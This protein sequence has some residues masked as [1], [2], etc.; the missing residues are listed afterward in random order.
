MSFTC[1]GTFTNNLMMVT[2][3][4]LP[5][6][7]SS[8]ST[9]H[10]L[11]ANIGLANLFACTVLKP[12]TSVYIG[13]G[14]AM[15]Q[16]AVDV[17]FC[18]LHTLASWMLLSVLPWSIMVLAWDTFFQTRREV[19]R[20]G[21]YYK[22]TYLTSYHTNTNE[23][24]TEA[25]IPI[26]ATKEGLESR[27]VSILVCIWLGAVV[28]GLESFET[29]TERRRAIREMII[30][31]MV[32]IKE[33]AV[34][35]CWVWKDNVGTREIIIWMILVLLPVGL[36]PLLMFLL[37]FLL[38]M[39][40]CCYGVQKPG[41]CSRTTQCCT[42]T[43]LSLLV[44]ISYSSYLLVVEKYIQPAFHLSQLQLFLLKYFLGSAD[45]ILAPLVICLLDKQLRQGVVFLYRRRKTGTHV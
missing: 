26:K 25:T 4:D 27:Q 14:Y 9:Y 24:K 13:Y 12:A 30:D 45:L 43:L 28:L 18:Q 37:Q 2:L 11:L 20:E 6:I 17:Q 36:G 41:I 32:V 15:T 29:Q 31:D 39:K 35:F 33:E 42:V 16:T 21:E 7:S 23:I 8:S 40:N 3:K 19:A 34:D 5:D 38:Y 1:F 22:E 10:I 44:V